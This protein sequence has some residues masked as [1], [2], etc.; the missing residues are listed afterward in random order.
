[1]KKIAVV[2]V[3][4]SDFSILL[5]LLKRIKADSSIQLDLLVSGGHLIANQGMTKHAFASAGFPDF[6]EIPGISD[7][8]DS[9]HACNLAIARALPMFSKVLLEL[10]SDL[11]IIMGDRF[12][13]F[14]AALAAVPLQI[15]ICHVHGGEVTAG[16]IDD[17]FRHAITKFAHLHC[18]A[19]PD[20]ARRVRQLGE[21]DWRIKVVGAPALDSLRNLEFPEK[22]VLFSELGFNPEEKLLLITFHPETL[23]NDG[24][25]DQLKNLLNA[26]SERPEQQLFTGSNVD[27]G[28]T[29]IM[30]AITEYLQIH[31]RARL[32]KSLGLPRYYHVL[33]HASALI[34]NS[35]SGIIE[36]PS[37]ALPCINIGNRQSGRIQASNIISTTADL[38]DL[39]SALARALSAEFKQTLT[40]MQSPYDQGDSSELILEFI[41]KYSR[42]TLLNKKFVDLKS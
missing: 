10:Q 24:G 21:E 27:P 22:N 15:P 31:P 17:Q 29:Q 6:H 40:G 5:P 2:S 33:K 20:Y 26:L 14:A 25:L 41:K 3:G 35:S 42:S 18:V 34:G 30:A 39:R 11:L 19:H 38:P 13:M 12:D 7:G 8:E 28:Q 9:P 32:V 4:R 1:M 23:T 37:F 16:A 36:S